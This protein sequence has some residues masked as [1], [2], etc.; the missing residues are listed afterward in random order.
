MRHDD[1]GSTIQAL[2]QF[3]AR[4][5]HPFLNLIQRLPLRGRKVAIAP[6]LTPHVGRNFRLTQTFVGAVVKFDP[7]F[8]DF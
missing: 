8:I 3:I 7:T 2:S 5:A 4:L 6:P 1:C